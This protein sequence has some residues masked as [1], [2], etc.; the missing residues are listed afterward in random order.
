VTDPSTAEP[1]ADGVHAPEVEDGVRPK[2]EEDEV[3]TPPVTASSN[4]STTC[5]PRAD[6]CGRLVSGNSRRRTAALP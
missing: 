1:D 5:C 2:V 4:A 3:V 6:C